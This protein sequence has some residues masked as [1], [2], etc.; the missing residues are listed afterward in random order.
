MVGEY[1][2]EFSAKGVQ[3]QSRLIELGF[4]QGGPAGYGWSSCALQVTRAA[5]IRIARAV[6]AATVLMVSITPPMVADVF[7]GAALERIAP[8][9]QCQDWPYQGGQGFA[10]PMLVRRTVGILVTPVVRR[11]V[12]RASA[13]GASDGLLRAVVRL[14]AGE[15]T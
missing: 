13:T 4:R 3:R 10:L 2:R 7:R 11:F 9:A 6:R 15:E 12:T 14:G 5:T 1:S 8:P